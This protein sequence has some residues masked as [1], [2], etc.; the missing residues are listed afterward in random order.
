MPRDPLDIIEQAESKGKNIPNYKFGP[1]F[2]AQGYYQITNPTWR[3]YAKAAGVD[4]SQYPTAMTAPRDVQRAVATQIFNKRGF[5]PWEAVKQLRGQEA[6]YSIGASSPSKVAYSG[7]TPMTM[8][9]TAP[10]PP[11]RPAEAQA[12]PQTV[13]NIQELQSRL[14]ERYPELKVTSG[15]RDP[16]HNAAVGGAKNSQHTHGRAIDM[17]FKGIDDARQREIVDYARQLGARGLGYY[18]NSQSVHFDV[19]TGAPAA[20]GQN[21]SRSSLPGTP[22]WFQEVAAQHMQGGGSPNT[23][24]ATSTPGA[25]GTPNAVPTLPPDPTAG[26]LASTP[27]PF[28]AIADAAKE[29]QDKQ[30]AQMAQ[31][32]AVT[33]PRPSQPAP[34]PVPDVPPPMPVDYAGLL[35]PRIK[36]GLLADDYSSGLLGAA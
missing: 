11:T 35:M 19:R 21:Y 26:V 6:N 15:Y 12:A 4:L 14:L 7:A 8:P 23:A 22:K 16:A 20:W 32:A 27:D 18:P 2:T 13:A 36:R 10:L 3:D 5:Q 29:R 34:P 9:G 25:V 28:K 30:Q 24:V 17:S 1:G 33:A 31:L